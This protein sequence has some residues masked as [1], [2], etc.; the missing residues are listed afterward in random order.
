MLGKLRMNALSENETEELRLLRIDVQ[1]MENK[2]QILESELIDMHQ[3]IENLK[4]WKK[5]RWIG[6]AF[7]FFALMLLLYI[8]FFF[9][10]SQF[11]ASAMNNGIGN[12]LMFAFS[13]TGLIFEC[14]LMIPLLLITLYQGFIL[15]V[16]VGNSAFARQYAC[17]TGRKNYYNETEN[18]LLNEHDLRIV[19]IELKKECR[20][21]KNRLEI[22]ESREK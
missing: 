9:S 20:E 5:N 1:Q 11:E 12:A 8:A 2:I 15:M 17:K 18:Y 3:T 7:C 16:E 4:R 21:A 10:D 19:I 13:S 6:F 14:C 22:L